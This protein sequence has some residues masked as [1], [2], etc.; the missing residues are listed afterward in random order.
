MK[1]KI[2]VKG[3]KKSLSSKAHSRKASGKNKASK[4]RNMMRLFKS[5]KHKKKKKKR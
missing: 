4:V 2:K 5:G 3:V 1:R